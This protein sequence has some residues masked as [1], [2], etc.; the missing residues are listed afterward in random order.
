MEINKLITNIVDKLKS[1]PALLS[2]FK[3]EPV[4]T[5]ESLSEIDL[6]DQQ[7]EMVITAVKAKLGVDGAA[8]VLNS[9]GGMLKK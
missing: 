7:V 1:D 9:L 3:K 6:P 2:S 4:K 5:L 8:C